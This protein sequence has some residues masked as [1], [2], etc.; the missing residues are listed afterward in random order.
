MEGHRRSCG[1]AVTISLGRNWQGDNPGLTPAGS[2]RGARSGWGLLGQPVQGF[3][4]GLAPRVAKQTQLRS[5]REGWGIWEGGLPG[6]DPGIWEVLEDG[7][8]LPW[9]QIPP[10]IFL[11]SPLFFP[12]LE[13]SDYC[14]QSLWPCCLRPQERACSS[15]R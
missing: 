10:V 2:G 6:T 7:E 15:L 14:I 8:Q 4:D 3:G 1:N 12:P 11:R 9:A 13:G 5:Q